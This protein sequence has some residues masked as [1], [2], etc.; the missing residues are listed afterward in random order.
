MIVAWLL[1]TDQADEVWLVPCWSHVFGKE[2]EPFNHRYTMC[3]RA[4]E[5][6][7]D[8]CKVSNIESMLGGESRTLRTIRELKRRHPG[9]R[10][11]LVI[12]TD[13]WWQRKKWHRFDLIEKECPIIVIGKRGQPRLPKIRSTM[14]RSRV[15]AGKNVSLFLSAR[16]LSYIMEQNLYDHTL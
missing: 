2:M 4:A 12:G 16:V 13:N 5:L 7:P 1:N 3:L 15:A 8:R 10:F 6:F 11:S 9:Y 14:I